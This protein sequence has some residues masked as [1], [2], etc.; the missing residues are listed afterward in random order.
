MKR[1]VLSFVLVVLIAIFVVNASKANL[2]DTETS[3]SNSATAGTLLLNLSAG[4]LSQTSPI[5]AAGLTPGGFVRKTVILQNGGSVNIS[6]VYVNSVY[7][8][9]SSSLYNKLGVR[10]Y[11]GAVLLLDTSLKNLSGFQIDLGTK[12]VEIYLPADADGSYQNLTT[13]W[14]F[15]FLG[16]Q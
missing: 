12:D 1:L 11:N 2:T 7:L 10:I 3:V 13:T 6:H 9:G 8:S 5:S 14:Q 15:N 4:T 16:Q